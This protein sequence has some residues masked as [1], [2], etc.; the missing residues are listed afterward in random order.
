M[1]HGR[2]RTSVALD[3][4]VFNQ[5]FHGYSTHT[6]EN[7]R[8]LARYLALLVGSKIAL[9][10]AL[11]TSGRFG[12]EREVV[13]KFIIDEIPVPSF[14]ALSAADRE[15]AA[16]LFDAL[17]QDDNEAGWQEVDRWVG[18][19]FGLDRDDM[20]TVA[21]TLKYRL[22]FSAN[23]KASQA[24]A[25][26]SQDATFNKRLQA[27]LQ[28]WGERFGRPLF[29]RRIPTSP[30]SP[31][32]FVSI[33]SNDDWGD[34]TQIDLDWTRTISLADR[35]SATEVIYVDDQAERLI[36]GRLNQARYWTPSQARLTARRIV[37]DHVDFLSGKGSQ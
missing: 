4:V 17:A 3:S 8:E 13:E 30:L 24:S 11:I 31:W 21:D 14:E 20:E 33:D 2:I 23:L 6:H 22:P 19:L 34:P 5:S 7:G 15:M 1:R 27:E 29:V 9:W 16:T 35:L 26:I 25:T 37:W 32:R 36:L 18:S 28:P 10:H 12:F